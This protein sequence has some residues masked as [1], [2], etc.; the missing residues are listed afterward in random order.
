[1]PCQAV[2]GHM[3]PCIAGF[4]CTKRLM[5]RGWA[6]ALAVCQPELPVSYGA[7]WRAACARARGLTSGHAFSGRVSMDG[8]G[9][10]SGWE[11][12]QSPVLPAGQPAS[13]PA[14]L[15]D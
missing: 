2:A 11:G 1:M 8:G 12:T 4:D 10:R 5:S 3:L 15:T 13:L 9:W 6:K 7:C 14:W